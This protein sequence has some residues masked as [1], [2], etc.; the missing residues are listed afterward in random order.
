VP[1]ALSATVSGP[2]PVS[3]VSAEDRSPVA[4]RAM[5]TS[6]APPA[7]AAITAGQSSL[8]RK[9][10]P[11]RAPRNASGAVP[12]AV[13]VTRWAAPAVPAAWA[14]HA[15]AVALSDASGAS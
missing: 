11:A 13:S 8:T 15:S 2:A 14:P 4:C 12:A 5:R 3:S 7:P 9:S 6:I 1:A 10:A